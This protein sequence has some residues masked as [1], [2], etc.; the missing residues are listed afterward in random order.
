LEREGFVP[1]I[2]EQIQ[3]DALDHTVPVSKLLREVKL[4]AAK[5]GLRAVEGW[6]DKELKGYGPNDDVPEYRN[7]RGFPVARGT[8]GGFEPIFFEQPNDAERFSVVPIGQSIPGIEGQPQS[9]PDAR[10]IFPYPPA[11]VEAINKSNK[12]PIVTCGVKFDS[13]NLVAIVEAVRTLVLEWA[14]EMERTGIKGENATFSQTEKDRAQTGPIAIHIGSIGSFT[15][16]LGVG[17]TAADVSSSV[18]QVDHVEQLLNQIKSHSAGLVKEGLNE[19]DL[20]R[21]VTEIESELKKTSPDQGVLRRLLTGLK[22]VVEGTAQ[23]LLTTGVL[24]LLNQILGVGVP[25]P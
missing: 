7:V 6:V 20:L 11:F 3:S 1:S 8:R 23:G 2:I 14:I 24:S 5:L 19:Q 25:T 13:S 17:N 12:R 9:G 4:A 10:L 15:G 16:N 21:R 18:I 22:S